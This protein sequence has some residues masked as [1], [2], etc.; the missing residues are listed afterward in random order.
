MK[1]R[2]PYKIAVKDF[3]TGAQATLPHVKFRYAWQAVMWCADSN[4][5]LHR[6]GCN[7]WQFV[8]QDPQLA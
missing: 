1:D 8:F 3:E 2:K 6:S 4:T 7:R 5:A